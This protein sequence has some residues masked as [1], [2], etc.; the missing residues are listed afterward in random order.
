MNVISLYGCET[1]SLTLRKEH[2]LRE[3]G[4]RVLR[5]FGPKREDVTEDWRRIHNQEVHYLH[6]SPNLIT[7]IK[8]RRMR[9]AGNAARMGEMGNG[10]NILVGKPEAK[11]TRKILE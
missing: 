5:T 2:R 9:Q 1:W 8:S 11:R 4:N 7:V 10:N 3:F 6:A